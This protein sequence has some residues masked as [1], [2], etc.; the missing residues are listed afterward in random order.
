MTSSVSSSHFGLSDENTWPFHSL[1]LQRAIKTCSRFPSI[2]SYNLFPFFENL[3]QGTSFCFVKQEPEDT[4]DLFTLFRSQFSKGEKIERGVLVASTEKGDLDCHPLQSK[5]D[6]HQRA[7]QKQL[8]LPLETCA[9]GNRV[10]Y[11][12]KQTDAGPLAHVLA[13]TPLTQKEK[14]VLAWRLVAKVLQL[15]DD[16][17]IFHQNIHPWNVL[18]QKDKKDGSWDVWLQNFL[19]ATEDPLS[20][21][22]SLNKNANPPEFEYNLDMTPQEIARHPYGAKTTDLYRLGLTLFSICKNKNFEKNF[23]DYLLKPHI[24]ETY[25]RTL[26]EV[27]SLEDFSVLRDDFIRDF[28]QYQLAEFPEEVYLTIRGLLRTIPDERI[29]LSKAL[30]LLITAKEKA[31]PCPF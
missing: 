14:I 13:T 10:F 19:G 17:K 20:K 6:F 29:P 8:A 26:K 7:A 1:C 16:C 9:F 23:R 21:E 4:L 24:K 11:N 25:F 15:H 22:K 27:S 18:V 28:L 31:R 30:S 2:G 3:Q 12:L 5:F